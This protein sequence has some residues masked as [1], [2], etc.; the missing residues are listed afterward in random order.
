[1]DDDLDRDDIGEEQPTSARKT[2]HNNHLSVKQ[3]E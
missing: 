2:P 3:Q 1:M